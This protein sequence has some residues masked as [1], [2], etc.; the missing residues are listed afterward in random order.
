MYIASLLLQIPILI[1]LKQEDQTI[2]YEWFNSTKNKGTPE[3]MEKCIC[4][5]YQ[6]NQF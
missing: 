4:L 1:V 6:G 5:E 2:G 3:E